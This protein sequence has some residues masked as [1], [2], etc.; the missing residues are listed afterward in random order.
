MSRRVSEILADTL[1]SQNNNQSDANVY[2]ERKESTKITFYDVFNLFVFMYVPIYT[3][4]AYS[5]HDLE[6]PNYVLG[7]FA[8]NLAIKIISFNVWYKILGCCCCCSKGSVKKI[9]AII[10]FISLTVCMIYT[11]T[12]ANWMTNNIDMFLQMPF[13]LID[14]GYNLYWLYTYITFLHYYWYFHICSYI[15]L[16]FIFIL[17]LCCCG[18]IKSIKAGQHQIEV[19]ENTNALN[20]R[21][22][23]TVF[24]RMQEHF[25]G[26]E[27]CQIC[28]VNFDEDSP[29]RQLPCNHF[30]H[31]GCADQW[32]TQNGTCPT[33]RTKINTTNPIVAPAAVQV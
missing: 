32:L 7:Y 16:G 13:K 6:I 8:F 30:F 33:C 31:Q 1:S 12:V 25:F 15:F 2:G 23:H 21:T 24:G 18:C 26:I 10:G 27:Q 20:A 5:H 28:L 17:L 29:I 14:H 3:I 22:I 9:R 11:F 19:R 4:V